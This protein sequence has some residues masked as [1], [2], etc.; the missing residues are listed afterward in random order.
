MDQ[1][2]IIRLL[3][4]MAAGF[5]ATRLLDLAWRAVTG[6]RPPTDGDDEGTSLREVVLFAAISGAIAALV[7]AYASKGATRYLAN[8]SH[9][10]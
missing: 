3:A 7:R 8:R 9:G 1:D 5:A 4:T 6:H 10:S 2:K